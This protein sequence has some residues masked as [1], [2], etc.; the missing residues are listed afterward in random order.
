MGKPMYDVF[1]LCEWTYTTIF[2]QHLRELLR[3]QEEQ[4]E[5]LNHGMTNKQGIGF[6]LLTWKGNVPQSF[7]GQLFHNQEVLDFAVYSIGNSPT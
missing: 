1:I 7:L 6:V 4:V 5:V 3:G 2:A